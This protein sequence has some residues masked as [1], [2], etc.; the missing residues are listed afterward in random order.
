M[1][2]EMLDASGGPITDD[3][4]TAAARILGVDVG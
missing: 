1:P 3:E 4:R 2:E